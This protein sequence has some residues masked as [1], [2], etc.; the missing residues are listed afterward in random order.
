M[1][2]NTKNIDWSSIVPVLIGAILGAILSLAGVIF[3][4][5]LKSIQQKSEIKTG[6]YTELKDLR[7]RMVLI[8]PRTGT[9]IG[10]SNRKTYEWALDMLDSYEQGESFILDSDMQA[11][12]KILELN[13]DNFSTALK[14]EKGRL[15]LFKKYSIPYLDSNVGNLGAF[16]EKEI[17]RIFELR[18]QLGIFNDMVDDAQRYYWMTMDFKKP[19]DRPAQLDQNIIISYQNI[20]DRAKIIVNCIDRILDDKQ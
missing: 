13:D 2:R 5:Y 3:D 16:N 12:R 4:D 7:M 11:I 1:N 8:V 18:S 9:S 14:K 10:T 6:I 15:I 19:E 17:A 20:K